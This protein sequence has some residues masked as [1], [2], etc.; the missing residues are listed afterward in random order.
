MY[1]TTLKEWR[2]KR[3]SLEA[4]NSHLCAE[5][6]SALGRTTR[7]ETE[8]RRKDALLLEKSSTLEA[9]LRHKDQL[10]MEA[11]REKK[12][13]WQTTNDS[14]ETAK[15]AMA[16]AE[17]AAKEASDLRSLR[18][19]ASWQNINRGQQGMMSFA[20]QERSNT[21]R[22]Q[23]LLDVLADASASASAPSTPADGGGSGGGG[24]E[25]TSRSWGPAQSDS[26]SG[27]PLTGQCDSRRRTAS[28]SPDRG[29]SV[30]HNLVP[31]QNELTSRAPNDLGQLPTAGFREGLNDQSRGALRRVVP[32][33]ATVVATEYAPPND[34]CV[35]KRK[36][37]GSPW[38]KGSGAP[39]PS[40]ETQE[41]PTTTNPTVSEPGRRIRAT[42]IPPA[43]GAPGREHCHDGDRQRHDSEG[44]KGALRGATPAWTDAPSQLGGRSPTVAGGCGG[45][46]GGD[47]PSARSIGFLGREY[48]AASGPTNNNYHLHEEVHIGDEKS[49][50]PGKVYSRYN[51][52]GVAH[53]AELRGE[54]RTRGGAGGNDPTAN[55]LSA[56]S[57]DLQPLEAP[58]QRYPAAG[59]RRGRDLMSSRRSSLSGAG[60]GVT[61]TTGEANESSRIDPADSNPKLSHVHPTVSDAMDTHDANGDDFDGQ[62]RTGVSAEEYNGA[63]P[64]T[65]APVRLGAASSQ[66]ITNRSRLS[67]SAERRSSEP[68]L[69]RSIEEGITA[70]SAAATTQRAVSFASM[71]GRRNSPSTSDKDPQAHHERLASAPFATDAVED[72]LRPVREV[73][74]RLMLLQ[75]ETSQVGEVM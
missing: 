3:Q 44:V 21:K 25:S 14:A 4:D 46:G 11:E 71:L 5:L 70:R 34:V 8:N 28:L 30:D 39:P 17:A 9:E 31:H 6:H 63:P 57:R 51:R 22:G 38:F 59:H 2:E 29:R 26:F 66:S 54:E 13:A 53:D 47:G 20:L 67:A 15:A 56:A 49:R 42:D 62:Q 40:Q 68:D 23:S 48:R 64:S 37:E 41:A 52:G 24:P 43:V 19:S 60:V 18:N 32:P 10:L 72:E 58:M 61:E 50:D 16:R 55:E 33:Q 36:K 75:M 65:S 73:E 7:L 35:G 1:N 69:K 74:R 45:G 27:L 12:R